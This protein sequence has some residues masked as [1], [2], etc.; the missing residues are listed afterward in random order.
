MKLKISVASTWYD[1]DQHAPRVRDIMKSTL[2]KAFR[3]GIIKDDFLRDTSIMTLGLG[4]VNVLNLIYQLILVR[5]LTIVE[6]GILSSLVAIILIASQFIIPFRP[7]LTRFLAVYI[8]QDEEGKVRVLMRRAVRDLAVISLF[9]LFIFLVLS[10]N[11]ARW[12]QI[13]NPTDVILVGIIISATTLAVVPAAFLWG[14]QR[15]KHLALLSA[16]PTFLKL[17]V[18][19][20][21]VWLG[22]GVAGALGGYIVF[23]V[24]MLII[25]F[26]I[27][28]S[29]RSCLP[30]GIGEAE[31]TISMMS[32]YKYYIPT[33][34]AL[35]S[36]TLLT[37]SD[38]VLVKHFF[39][40]QEA[41][42]YSI[43]QIVGKIILFLPGAVVAVV[44]PKAAAAQAQNNS[45]F[46]ILKKG[47]VIIALSNIFA[48]LV[49]VLF[50]NAVLKLL[51]GKTNAESAQ[52]VIWFALAMSFYA[53]T[54]LNIFYNLS[55][56]QFRFILYLIILSVAQTA[57]IYIYHPNLISVI[58]ILTVFSILSFLIT[59][60]LSRSIT[61]KSNN[62]NYRELI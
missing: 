11:I 26:F 2:N 8:A 3:F 51:T 37:N 50:P 40:P 57:A 46:S 61:D 9:I 13:D 48:T 45:S 30:K 27:I 1:H 41:G 5:L 52:L 44:F 10:D 53:L 34:L 39:S 59:L 18:G 20:I 42:F 23:P 60:Y 33:G 62:K 47:L 55:I 54:W 43:A 58:K 32:I 4:I 29:I 15:F 56:N 22:W 31:D 17:L 49:C 14:T 25:G 19:I 24:S 6:F 7:V 16:L 35:F 38:V 12:Q 21:L 28:R 36:F